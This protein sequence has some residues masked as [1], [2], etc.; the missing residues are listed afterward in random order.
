MGF[1]FND[2]RSYLVYNSNMTMDRAK[3]IWGYFALVTALLLLAFGVGF[4]GA[5]EV[6]QLHPQPNSSP[7]FLLCVAGASLLGILAVKLLKQDDRIIYR[8]ERKKSRPW[9][10]HWLEFEVRFLIDDPMATGVLTADIINATNGRPEQYAVKDLENFIWS[11][12]RGKSFHPH[13][14]RPAYYRVREALGATL[15][16]PKSHLRPSTRLEDVFPKEFR[17]ELWERFHI[18]LGAQVP[19]LD[20]PRAFGWFCVVLMLPFF[21]I[22]SVAAEV[23]EHRLPSHGLLGGTLVILL[24]IGIIVGIGWLMR[25]V[26]PM[27]TVFSDHCQTVGDLAR[28]IALANLQPAIEWDEASVKSSVREMLQRQ[29]GVDPKEIQPDATLIGNLGMKPIMS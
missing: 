4:L 17:S 12:L 11:R 29:S 19:P 15:R 27:D 6:S 1:L 20:V 24:S 18:H 16:I 8:S 28:I 13:L 3:K 22:L 23:F 10:L 25:R 26:M 5:D 9:S 2:P 7:E 21:C 14:L